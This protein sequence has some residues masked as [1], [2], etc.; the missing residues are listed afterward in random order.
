[1]RA[2]VCVR[3]CA[4]VA[5]VTLAEAVFVQT[6]VARVSIQPVS[7]SLPSRYRNWPCDIMFEFGRADFAFSDPVWRPAT[8]QEVKETGADIATLGMKFLQDV[9]V[10]EEY[11]R[12][13]IT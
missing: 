13:H 4:R 10:R 1:M 11:L 7:T 3:V 8:L 2:R 6:I 5:V 9:S 12:D